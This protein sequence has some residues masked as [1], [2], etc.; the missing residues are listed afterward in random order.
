MSEYYKKLKKLSDEEIVDELLKNKN[1]SVFAIL[2][3]RSAHKVYY[4]CLS[5]SND[6]TVAE[7][8]AHDIFL[9]CF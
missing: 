4:K 6:K 2:Y 8:L 7:D 5:F 9:K 3:Q 1:S